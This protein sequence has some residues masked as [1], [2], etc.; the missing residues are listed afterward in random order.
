MVD[1]G[2]D[3]A[4]LTWTNT[5]GQFDSIVFRT[6]NLTSGLVRISYIPG[7]PNPGRYF[8]QGLLPH[9]MYEIEAST[10]CAG[11]QSGWSNL[12][13]VTTLAPRAAAGQVNI[14]TRV[15]IT[16]NPATTTTLI[17]FK[18]QINTTQDVMITNSTGQIVYRKTMVATSEKVQLPVDVTTFPNGLYIVKLTSSLGVTTERMIVQ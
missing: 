7:N 3:K 4:L 14:G 1:M 18:S 8:M 2:F 15:Y 13:T 5:S 10:I 9:T 11:V 17:S 12:I 6:T 16:P